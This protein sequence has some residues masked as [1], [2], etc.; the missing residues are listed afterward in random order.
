[1]LQL[2]ASLQP[3]VLFDQVLESEYTYSVVRLLRKEGTRYLVGQM[4][5]VA[6]VP[7]TITNW[8]GV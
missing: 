3:G 6:V 7:F 4:S 1:M 2:A 5:R 8:R